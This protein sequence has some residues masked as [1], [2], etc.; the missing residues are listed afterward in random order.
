[1]EDYAANRKGKQPGTGIMFGTTP[2]ATQSAGFNFGT[3]PANT[4]SRKSRIYS[5]FFL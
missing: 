4:G 1:M 5:D 3:M 2:A